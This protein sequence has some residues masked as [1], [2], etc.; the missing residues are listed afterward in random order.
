[1]EVMKVQKNAYTGVGSRNTPLY[2]LYMMSK[3]AMILEKKGYIL[4]SGCA[5]GADAAF[6][7][8]LLNP[9]KSAEIYIPN[10]GFPYKMGT[11]YKNH[12]IIPKDKFGESFHGLYCQATRLIH[13]KD[14]HKL[15]R[16]IKSSRTMDLH[17]RNMFQVLGI[18]LKS[19]SKFN[20]CFTKRQELKYEDTGKETGGTGTSINASSLYDIELFNLSVDEHYIRL[21][22]LIDDNQDLI[23]YDRLN[24]IIVRTDYNEKKTDGKFKYDYNHFMERISNERLI[25]ETKIK[26]K[27]SV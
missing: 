12:Y 7:D 26:E 25:R 3:I 15:W 5:T 13:Q 11:N 21:N 6:E 27:A 18:D 1:M 2:I 8:A 10:K 14:I 9:S 4:R 16:Y 17:N 20:I 19:K 22:K 24:K 23:D